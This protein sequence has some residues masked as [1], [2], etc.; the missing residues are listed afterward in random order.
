LSRLDS[1]VSF[2]IFHRDIKSSVRAVHRAYGA[3][4]HA[5][6]TNTDCLLNLL[7]ELVYGIC[8]LS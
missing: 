2:F 7:I 1:V 5:I 4:A 6:K 8:F 3:V